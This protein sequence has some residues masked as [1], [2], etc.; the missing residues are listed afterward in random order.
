ML[1][2]ALPL[3]LLRSRTQQSLLFETDVYYHAAAVAEVGGSA[4][5]SVFGHGGRS[6]EERSQGYSRN[7]GVSS[8]SAR[9]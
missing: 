7:Q 2:L 5:E 9:I 3:P 4:R 1:P 6:V 8:L